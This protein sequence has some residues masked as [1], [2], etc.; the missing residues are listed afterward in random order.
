[1]ATIVL[2][3]TARGIRVESLH[4]SPGVGGLPGWDAGS[5]TKRTLRG[6]K[7]DGVDLVEVDSGSLRLAILPTRGMGLWKGSYRGD[8]L[9]WKSPITDGPV[10]PGLVNLAGLGG[11]GWLDGF[12]ELMVRCG[13]ESVGPPFADGPFQQT[14]H[15]RIA[16]LP[17]HYLAVHVDEQS[18]HDLVV[19]GHVD[20]SR[21]FGPRLR[22][23]TTVTFRPGTNRVT[24]RDEF[25]NLKD[26]PGELE[27]LYH[28]NFGPPHLEEGSR[29]VAPIR[30]LAP[31]DATSEKGLADYETYGPP[32]AGF[33]EE[34]FFL[35]LH[36]AGP[37]GRTLAMLRNKGGDKGIAL[38]F[39]HAEMPTFTVWKNTGPLAD[40]YV[41]GLEPGTN[42]PNPK[43]H[44]RE[45]GRI[46]TLAPGQSHVAETVL[47]V[48]D[49][50]EAVA[51]IAA[52]VAAL[53]TKGEPVVYPHP[54]ESIHSA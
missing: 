1:M 47:E 48:L 51:R 19:E 17:A 53:Q 50:A 3:D 34:A 21:L 38:R 13:L 5:L 44:E 52:E 16:N 41:T 30:A 10:H 35:K 33:A 40:G 24:V 46:M 11:L 39:S 6:G 49:T 37:D 18:P 2:T 15:G 54:T 26:T 29:L 20:E 42:F 28:W 8:S 14:L 9:G 4:L 27:V 12:D 32:T 22:M 7:S 23:K 25:I 36:S 31:R 43:P 45:K